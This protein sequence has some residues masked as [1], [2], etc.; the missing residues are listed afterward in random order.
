MAN[1]FLA[2]I[3]KWA[4]TGVRAHPHTLYSTSWL[5]ALIWGYPLP[6][7]FRYSGKMERMPGRDTGFWTLTRRHSILTPPSHLLDWLDSAGPSQIFFSSGQDQY[8][9]GDLLSGISFT[10]VR[11]IWGQMVPSEEY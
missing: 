1:H 2:S 5:Y 8:V 9:G 3:L 7:L 10:P 11:L 6:S 4:V